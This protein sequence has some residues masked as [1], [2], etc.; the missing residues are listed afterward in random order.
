MT[1]EPMRLAMAGS[2][3]TMPRKRQIA[4]AA[5]LKSTRTRMNLKKCSASGIKP[6]MGYTIAPMMMGGMRR[7]GIMSNM[8]FARK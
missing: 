1:R 6:V 3:Q 8:T 4:A 7:R 2:L 5:R